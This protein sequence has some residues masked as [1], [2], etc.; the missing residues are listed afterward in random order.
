MH[1]A[2]PSVRRVGLIGEPAAGRG[3]VGR[4][5]I[6]RRALLAVA[7]GIAGP[8]LPRFARAAEVTWRIGHS[9]PTELPLH[10]RLAEAAATI[11]ARS[12]G[13]MEVKIYPDNQLGIPVGMLGQLRAGTIDA[14]PLTNEMLAIDL[15]VAA[16]PTLGFAFAGYD[17]LWPAMDGDVGQFLRSRIEER[18]G[19]TTMDRCWDFGF[20]QLTTSTKAV[21][22]AHDLAGLRLRT[23]PDADFIAL[24][25]ALQALPLAIPFGALSQAISSHAID[26]QESV[27]ALVQAAGLVRALPFCALTNHVWDGSWL[28]V[29]RNSWSKLPANLK[30]VVAAALNESALHQRQDTAGAEAALRTELQAAGM[31]FNPVDPED[32]RIALSES[33]YYTARHKKLGDEGW[34]TLQKYTGSLVSR[35]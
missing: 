21:K 30:D 4:G 9:A 25:R 28:C 7:A 19:L 6:R 8:L 33:G 27:L 11:A 34:A 35:S 14:V 12:D 10:I 2:K 18:L 15:A 22:T 5:P 3:V 1:S 16:L 32:F 23:P 17:Q 24:F 31:I 20:R 13:R 26:G 29:S